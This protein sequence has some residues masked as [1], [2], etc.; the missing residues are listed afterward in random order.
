MS[1]TASLIPLSDARWIYF[2]DV[3]KEILDKKLQQNVK[4]LR[5]EI[6]NKAKVIF[7][8]EVTN[9]D[10]NNFEVEEISHAYLLKCY[11][12]EKYPTQSY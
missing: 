7:L 3:Y 10:V 11:L 6:S 5:E 8:D 4:F 2:I 1:S 12:E 9:S